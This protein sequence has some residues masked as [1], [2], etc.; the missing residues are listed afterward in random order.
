AATHRIGS[1]RVDGAVA[2]QV[3]TVQYELCHRFP[4]VAAETLAHRR[5]V[6]THVEVDCV[7]AVSHVLRQLRVDKL[8]EI[9]VA[10]V[11]VNDGAGPSVIDAPLNLTP[12]PVQL[13][14]Q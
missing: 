10:C 7:P 11:V 14:L 4:E 8:E 2:V 12:A 9:P 1:A 13:R 6:I 3:P 5:E